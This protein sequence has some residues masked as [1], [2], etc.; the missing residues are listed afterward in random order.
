[1]PI[2]YYHVVFTIPEQLND[3]AL[4]N[5]SLF[6]KL[7]FETTAATL[8]TIAA[9]PKR[10][11]AKIGFFS[12][13]H[14]WGQNLLFH[15]H[16][17]CV[18][19]GGGVSPDHSQWIRCKPGF[20]LPVRVLSA[21][22][23]RLLLEAL[24]R[25]FRHQQLQFPG[26]IAALADPAAFA[27][28]LQPLKRIDWV[29]HAK[30]PFGGPLQ[31]LQYLGRYTHRVALSNQRILAFDHGEVTFQYKDYRSSNPQKSRRMTIAADEFIRRFLLHSLP[32]GFQRIRHYGH[33]AS[34]K[35]KE[36]L[37]LCRQLLDATTDGLLPSI[38]QVQ[39]V[40]AELLE[41]SREC[42]CCHAGLMIR[43]RILAP[44]RG[45]NSS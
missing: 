32:P 21:L 7:L 33:F 42:T 16:I 40:V 13:L 44:V 12:I 30:P 34:R 8:Q 18:V 43:T 45:W 36:S 23:R 4:R 41:Q 24:D 10:L 28:L 27:A 14:T 26:T 2:D 6:Y 17:H 31:V 5:Q 11:G 25:A 20:F 22:F 38:A 9:D 15:P 35:K 1:M 3:L 37:A 39:A 29:V 19:T